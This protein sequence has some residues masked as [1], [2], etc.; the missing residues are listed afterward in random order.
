MQTEPA[1]AFCRVLAEAAAGKDFFEREGY[2]VL[3]GALAPAVCAEAV[4]GFLAEVHLDTRA[5]F[6]RSGPERY[7]AHCYTDT[8]RMRFPI[9][10]LQDVCGRR[11]PQF[12]AAGLALLT[13]RA[14]VRA[15]RTLLG[16]PACLLRTMYCD[17]SG[18]APMQQGARIG[19]WIAAEDAWHPGA[20]ALRQGDVLLWNAT[21]AG[22]RW[23]PAVAACQQR[24]LIG[25]Y[26]A[27]AQCRPRGCVTIG[28]IDVVLHGGRPTVAGR[29]AGALRTACPRLYALL[30]RRQAV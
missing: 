8:G 14:L 16:E 2:L 22:A 27:R 15:V 12:K 13:D 24:A 25:Y 5:L 21:A 4:D 11:Y 1:D 19:A 10:N 28:G 6:L 26:G 9:V 29:A 20:T 23:P 18:A 17:G 3:R 30:Q 7:A